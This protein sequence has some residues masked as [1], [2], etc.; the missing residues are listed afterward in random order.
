MINKGNIARILMVQVAVVITCI[1]ISSFMGGLEM[2]SSDDEV[3]SLYYDECVMPDNSIS[4]L[5]N[6]SFSAVHADITGLNYKT[7]GANANLLIS[8]EPD[9]YYTIQSFSVVFEEGFPYDVTCTMYYPNEANELDRSRIVT[10]RLP[11]DGRQLYVTIPKGSYHTV[12]LEMNCNFTIKDIL[13]SEDLCTGK[14]SIKNQVN[15]KRIALY[16]LLLMVTFEFILFILWYMSDKAKI[17]PFSGCKMHQIVVPVFGVSVFTLIVISIIILLVKHKYLYFWILLS[18]LCCMIVGSQLLLLYRRKSNNL[19]TVSKDKSNIFVFWIGVMLFC[20]MICFVWSETLNR[21]P[22]TLKIIETQYI[23]VFSIVETIMLSLLYRRY[24]SGSRDDASSSYA[25]ILAYVI[26]MLCIF[27]MLVFLP[28]MAPDELTHYTLGYRF[29]NILLGKIGLLG[30][31]RLLMRIEDYYFYN[32]GSKLQNSDYFMRTLNS[33]KL[34]TNH[35]GYV[36]VDCVLPTNSPFSFVFSGLGIAIGRIMNLGAIPTYYLGRI[37]NILFFVFSMRYAIRKIPFGKTALFCIATF[38]MN[39]HVATSFSYD[40]GT[41]C[42]AMFFIVQ[43]LYIAYSNNPIK[44]KDIALCG[45]FSAL[46]GPSK[47]VYSPLLLSVFIIPNSRLGKSKRESMKWKC[48]IILAGLTSIVIVS[49]FSRVFGTNSA[50]GHMVTEDKTGHVLPWVNEEGYTISWIFGHLWETILIFIRTVNSM[51]NTFFFELVGSYLSW[52]N[53]YVPYVYSAFFFALFIL[54][55]NTKDYCSQDNGA[56]IKEKTWI[57]LLCAGSVAASM[58][59]MLLSWT[60]HSYNYVYGVQG[61]YFL[62]LLIPLL[63]VLSNNRSSGK[64]TVA[65]HLVFIIAALNIWVCIY[66]FTHSIL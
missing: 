59:A 51:L 27:Y 2:L 65:K 32:A 14:Y 47:V 13:I 10:V 42:F 23:F 31:N 49:A 33:V 20:G 38:P 56:G 21:I 36:I 34:F 54:S 18:G 30:D 50:V 44:F 48:F 11:K 55:A 66:V 7:N 57:G 37:C 40:G 45:L 43:V 52:L 9:L 29:S 19:K 16:A 17:T 3:D 26:F 12:M 64:P 6:C 39:L 15:L 46:L 58:L 4:I 5:N 63:I 24:L 41:F 62:P 53:L 22:D 61:R 1:I 28:F 35:S 8:F 25:N 60:P